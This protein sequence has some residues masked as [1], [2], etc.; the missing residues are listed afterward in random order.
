[1][2]GGTAALPP[3]DYVVAVSLAR[4]SSGTGTLRVRVLGQTV[5]ASSGSGYQRFG[6]TSVTLAAATTATVEAYADGFAD[7]NRQLVELLVA[8]VPAAT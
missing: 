5:T 8:I 2:T 7:S 3:G 4:G 6:P 1:M